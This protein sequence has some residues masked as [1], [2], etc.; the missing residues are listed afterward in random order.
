MKK[1]CRK[2]THLYLE[3]KASE[4]EAAAKIDNFKALNS[5]VKELSGSGSKSR[6]LIKDD[7][8]KTV[9]TRD[10]NTSIPEYWDTGRFHNTVIPV[11][12]GPQYR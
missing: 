2:D 1:S 9:S 11:S 8:G 7:N 3:N 5:I 10:R 4:A 12:K 6:M